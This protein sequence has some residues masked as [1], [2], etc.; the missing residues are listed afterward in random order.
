M[1]GNVNHDYHILD[2]DIWPLVGAFSGLTFTSGMVLY[3]HDMANAWLVL[4]LGI[5]GL[6]ATF[7][8]WFSKVVNEAER[9]DPRLS[10][11]FTCVT[12]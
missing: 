6:I 11:S 1:A 3:M 5:A 7:W 10:C 9:G 2:P 8:G 4:G 12:A